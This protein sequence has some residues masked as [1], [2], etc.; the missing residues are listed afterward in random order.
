M[1]T[2]YAAVENSKRASKSW[3]SQL[4]IDRRGCCCIAV[5]GPPPN[6]PDLAIYSQEEQFAMGAVP[7]WDNPDLLTNYWSPFKLMPET[8]VTVRNLSS[9]TAAVNVQVSLYTSAFGIGAARDLMSSLIVHLAPLHSSTLLFPMTQALLNSA[10]Q[11]IGVYVKITHPHDRRQI[12]NAGAQL[13]ADAYT[14][15]SGRNFS[16]TF[17]ITN[18]LSTPQEI[19]VA[20]FPNM[21]GATITPDV[22]TFSPLEQVP[23]TMMLHVPS[24]LHG[25][26][27]APDRQEVTVVAYGG[28]GRIIGGLTY[29]IW[30]DD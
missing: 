10:E 13:L 15:A 14:S 16:V 27:A 6:R 4:R 9:T 20:A 23:A 3:C 2:S 29:V 30:I 8:S 28:D 19:S 22:R 24:T 21:L 26:P 25:T 17:P 1:A 5:D 18:P 11:R 12:N 7:T